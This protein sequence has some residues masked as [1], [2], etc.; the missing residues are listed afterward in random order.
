[1]QLDFSFLL[2]SFFTFFFGAVC[3]YLVVIYRELE[4]VKKRLEKIEKYLDQ[5]NEATTELGCASS[6]SSLRFDVQLKEF[7]RQKVLIIKEVR[8]L[9]GLGLRETKELV[10]SA[11][12]VLQ[13]RMSH[14]E[15]EGAK[16]RLEALGAVV[17]IVQTQLV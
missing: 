13:R 6:S 15:A 14:A 4:A 9:T 5:T 10:E 16:K 3:Y 11:P 1:M 7:G 8:A 17:E 12:V 2:R